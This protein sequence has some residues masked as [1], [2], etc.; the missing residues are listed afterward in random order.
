MGG[1]VEAAAAEG[2][3]VEEE[4]VA[5]NKILPRRI[6]CFS[7]FYKIIHFCLWYIKHKTS[8][9]RLKASLHPDIFTTE[10]SQNSNF[11]N[12]LAAPVFG[13]P[14]VCGKFESILSFFKC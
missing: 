1:I 2:I 5:I 10:S 8:G 9:K 6:L 11:V 12:S 14:S 7:D 3:A 13:N 4:G